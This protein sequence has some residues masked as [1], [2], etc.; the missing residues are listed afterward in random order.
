MNNRIIIIGAGIVGLAIAREL[1][2]NGYKKVT[3]IDKEKTIASHQSSRNSGV[4]HAGLYYKPGSLKA[5]LS[6]LGINYMKEYCKKNKIDFDECGKIVIAKN[7]S[8][9]NE[10]E[11]LFAKGKKNNLKGIK[12]ISEKK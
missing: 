8:E 5:K 2:L 9:I 6:R 10:L 11:N 3:I 1:L 4:M 7:K 12:V